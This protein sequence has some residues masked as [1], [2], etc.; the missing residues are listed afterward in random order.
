MLKADFNSD[1]PP[2]AYLTDYHRLL[3]YHIKDAK[4]MTL[5]EVLIWTRFQ[6]QFLL[7]IWLKDRNQTEGKNHE[8]VYDVAELTS[9]KTPH[10]QKERFGG[11]GERRELKQELSA[12]IT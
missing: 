11:V 9:D 1:I 7:L 2:N 10:F 3:Q 5:E 6:L 4:K 8:D 12:W